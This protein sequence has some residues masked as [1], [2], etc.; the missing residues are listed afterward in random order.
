MP[1]VDQHSRNVK[2]GSIPIGLE[3]CDAV[4][5]GKPHPILGGN[6]LD[7]DKKANKTAVRQRLC[8]K[9]ITSTISL[10]AR[11]KSNIVS[12]TRAKPNTIQNQLSQIMRKGRKKPPK[13]GSQNK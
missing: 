8:Q 6:N 4:A 11:G 9:E 2:H 1:Y 12:T 7:I 10:A 5:R 3:E 13:Y